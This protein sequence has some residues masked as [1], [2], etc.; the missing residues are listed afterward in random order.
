M[1]AYAYFRHARKTFSCE[2]PAKTYLVYA[3]IRLAS[4]IA[5]GIL[6]FLKHLGQVAQKGAL[7]P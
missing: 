7:P 1:F 2:L 3:Y 5:S 4:T 6:T